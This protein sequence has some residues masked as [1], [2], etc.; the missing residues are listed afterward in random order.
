MLTRKQKEKIIDLNLKDFKEAN[1]FIFIDFTGLKF[2]E[3]QDLRKK[4][5]NK[6]GILRALKRTLAD[7]VFGKLNL[8]TKAKEFSGSSLAVAI[9]KE[10]NESDLAKEIYNF[11]KKS[12]FCKI[13][14]GIIGGKFV[15]PDF[16]VNLAKLPSREVLLGRVVFGVSSPLRGL[17]NVL[18]GNIRGLAVVLSKIKK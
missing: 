7:I 1:A 14:G 5:K 9:G 18:S 3:M 8:P 17:V 12:D 11:S 10:K 6:A 13:L 16:I 4:I 15:S 2:S